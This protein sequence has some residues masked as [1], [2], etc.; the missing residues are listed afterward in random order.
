MS[1]A[2]LFLDEVE[3][4]PLSYQARD[5]LDAIRNGATPAQARAR[6]RVSAARVAIWK[7]FERFRDELAAAEDGRGVPHAY[8][9]NKL[10]LP[11]AERHPWMQDDTVAVDPHGDAS[12]RR[13]E[14][15]QPAPLGLTRGQEEVLARERGR[16]N[17]PPW[18]WPW[19]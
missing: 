14:T 15:D 17:E 4:K 16:G 13:R 10:T 9:M 1:F 3:G 6:A 8:D 11:G 7:Q 2:G 19:K 5:Y 12:F 18:W